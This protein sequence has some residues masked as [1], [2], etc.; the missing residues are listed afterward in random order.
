[1]ERELGAPSVPEDEP[2]MSIEGAHRDIAG[3][4][5]Q[6]ARLQQ[7][8]SREAGRAAD[9]L[10]KAAAAMESANKTSNHSTK[11]SKV[12]EA[13]RHHDDAAKYQKQVA[14]IES[15]ISSEQ[16][17]LNDAQKKLVSEQERAHRKQLQEQERAAR[18][19]EKRMRQLSGTI[20]QHAEL[21]ATTMRRLDLLPDRINVLFLASNPRDQQQ[22]LL[23]E[24]VRSISE[25]IRKS[26][27]RDAVRL[28]S[29]WALRPLDL[30]QA[31]NEVKPHVVH[32]SAHGSMQDEIVFQD[33]Q[34]ASKVVS[35]EAIV[36]TMAATAANIQLVFFNTCYSRAQAEAVV[37]HVASAIGMNTTIGDTAARVFASQFYSAVGF[38]HSVAKAFAQAKAALMLEGIAE[39]STPELFLASGVDAEEL[40]L[41]RPQRG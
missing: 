39:E 23:D 8:K 16:K 28:E 34:G 38:G 24:E 13:Q 19:Q 17:K 18:E 12:R 33:D 36:Q 26:L 31:L 27:H 35:K 11:A 9:A 14:N 41:V 21:H 2:V 32:F 3:H 25:T 10:R 40:V 1:M 6:I 5:H 37:H 20:A 4:Q 22:L 29:R 15:K 30:L 7:E